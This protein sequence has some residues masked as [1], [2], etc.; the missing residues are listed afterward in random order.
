MEEEVLAAQAEIQV[1]RDEADRLRAEMEDARVGVS[2]C[3]CC[4]LRN[5]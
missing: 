5:C 1:T 2:G 4:A 3:W